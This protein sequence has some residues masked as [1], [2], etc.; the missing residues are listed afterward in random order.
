MGIVLFSSSCFS[1]MWLSHS[2]RV[3]MV[4]GSVNGGLT[5]TAAGVRLLTQP[6]TTTHAFACLGGAGL[7][8]GVKSVDAEAVY[9]QLWWGH[10]NKA[11]A[12]SHVTRSSSR[13]T[14]RRSFRTN[15]VR[16]QCIL[17][18]WPEGTAR[19]STG[20]IA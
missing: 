2:T 10:R 18:N 20:S 11:P 9:E 16:R 15:F 17:V 5:A 14:W 4:I 12:P 7:A 6:N 8:T 19:H 3:T 1:Y 13:N